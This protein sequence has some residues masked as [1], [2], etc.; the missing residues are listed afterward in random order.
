MTPLPRDRRDPRDPRDPRDQYVNAANTDIAVETD[1]SCTVAP[2]G[3]SQELWGPWGPMGGPLGAHG[4][5][6]GA[7]G[8]PME[9]HGGSMG[10]WG[11]SYFARPS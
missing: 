10:S 1:G 8:V 5:P 7:H 9:T 11:M 6:W 3:R 2:P 4:C